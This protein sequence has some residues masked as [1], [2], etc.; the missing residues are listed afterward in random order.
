MKN[1]KI[2]IIAAHPDDEVLGCFGTIAKYIQ[3]G[4]EAYT[5]ILGEGKTSREI[6]SENEQEILEDELFKANNLLGIKKVFRKFFPDNAFDKIPLLEIVKSIE[7]VK[8]EI[9]PNIIFTHYEKD[10]NIDHQ[11]TYKATITATRSLQEESVKEIYSFEILSSTEWNYPLS[12]QPNV[13]FDISETLDLKLKAMSFYQSELRNYPHP[14]SLEGIKINAQYQGMR[15]GLQ[16]AEVFKS[17]KVI[18]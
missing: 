12:F 6:N 8:N 10:L 5:L 17:I 7:E 14:R 3:Q 15:V 1:N 16:Y 9:K 18:K 13:F 11:I 4:Y 2:L